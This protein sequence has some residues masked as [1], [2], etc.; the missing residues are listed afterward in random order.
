[1]SKYEKLSTIL[2]VLALIAA[3]SSPFVSY[4]WLDPQLQAFRNRARLQ[5]TG[6]YIDPKS[7]QSIDWKDPKSL[8]EVLTYAYEVKI[9]NIGQLPGK[10]IKIVTTNTSGATIAFYPPPTPTPTPSVTPFTFSPPIPYDI[11]EKDGQKFITITRALAPND[12]L[13]MTFDL[14]PLTIAVSNDFGETTLLDTRMSFSQ[15]VESLRR[16]PPPI[17]TSK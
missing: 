11:I 10:D 15:V 9:T 2:S 3:I 6:T 8:P 17:K 12:T 14:K 16:A 1:M 4:R 5:V 13:I 7:H